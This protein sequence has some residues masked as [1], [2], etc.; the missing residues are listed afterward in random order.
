MITEVT[1]QERVI[2]LML[3]HCKLT[4]ELPHKN[5]HLT[6][7]H[8]HTH[9]INMYRVYTMPCAPHHMY[10][11]IPTV[12]TCKTTPRNYTYLYKCTYMYVDPLGPVPVQGHLQSFADLPAILPWP[13]TSA[14]VVAAPA[15]G[16]RRVSWAPPS[17][18]PVGQQN[19]THALAWPLVMPC[20]F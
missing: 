8:T 16:G 14:A 19:R 20:F 4:G 11:Y 18:P 9:T 2:N 12:L 10:M 3:Y 1:Y 13:L 17:P 6:N 5:G 7:K 15:P